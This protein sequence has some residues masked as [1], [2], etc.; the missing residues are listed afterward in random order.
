MGMAVIGSNISVKIAGGG[1]GAGSFTT[2]P[3]EYADVHIGPTPATIVINGISFLSTA[4]IY[5]FKV[6]PSSTA[7]TPANSSYVLFRN[8]P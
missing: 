3:N 5:K 8:S 4:T 6:P 2:G 7:S 1:S